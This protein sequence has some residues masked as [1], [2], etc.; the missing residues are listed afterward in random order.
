MTKVSGKET[1]ALRIGVTG[2][3]YLRDEGTLRAGLTDALR[4]IK[5]VYPGSSFILTS[6]LAEGADRLVADVFMQHPGVKLVVPLPMP[7]SEYMEDFADANSQ[8]EFLRLLGLADEVILLP[9]EPSRDAAYEAAGL[10]VLEHCDLL[11]ALWDGVAARGRGGTGEIV[12]RAVASGK[13]VCHI[14]AGNNHPDERKHTD[15]DKKHGQ[16]RWFNFGAGP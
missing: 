7:R 15:V 13:P 3:R 8:E 11:V 16:Y 2:H 14:W 6:P 1:A 9:A 10:Y 4:K 5:K 12:A